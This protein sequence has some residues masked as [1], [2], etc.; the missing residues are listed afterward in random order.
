VLHSPLSFLC[1]CTLGRCR[2][3][4][5][6]VFRKQTCCRDRDWDTIS[7]HDDLECVTLSEPIHPLETEPSTNL[8]IILHS[9]LMTR[10]QPLT[11]T[12]IDAGLQSISTSTTCCALAPPLAGPCPALEPSRPPSA[13][14]V[15]TST[16]HKPFRDFLLFT[17]HTKRIFTIACLEDL[18]WISVHNC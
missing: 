18:L 9:A 8:A 5:L 2:L 15:T 10:S 1:D 4:A 3:Y 7:T 14:K 6:G 12:R 16:F 17:R 13:I 11:N